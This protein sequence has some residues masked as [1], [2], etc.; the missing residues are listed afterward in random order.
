MKSIVC[1]LILFITT[2]ISY[3]QNIPCSGTSASGSIQILGDDIN[4]CNDGVHLY[5]DVIGGGNAGYPKT[6][7]YSVV[8]NAVFNPV[9]WVLANTPVNVNGFALKSVDDHW[10]TAIS[11]PFNF[12]FFGQQYSSLIIGNNGQVCFDLSQIGSTNIWFITGNPPM[13]LFHNSLNNCIVSPFFDIYAPAFSGSD[14]TYEILGTAPCRK[15]AVSWNACPAFA[16]TGLQS[17]HQIILYEG[18][19]E[20]EIN[21]LNKPNCSSYGYWEGIQNA[22]GTEAYN[23]PG[24]NGSQWTANN[25]S[26]A[27]VPAGEPDTNNTIYWMDSA[28]NICIGTGDT[29]HYW[30]LQEMAVYVIIGD[31]AA[32]Q[33]CGNIQSPYKHLYVQNAIVDWTSTEISTCNGGT[34]TFNITN[35]NATSFLW[36]FGDG[37]TL[38]SSSTSVAHTYI[39]L[40]PFTVTCSVAVGTCTDMETHP[41]IFTPPPMTADFTFSTISYCNGGIVTLNINNILNADSF[42]WNFG[43]GQFTTSSTNTSIIHT[44]S[45][46]GPFMAT[47]YYYSSTGNC[48]DS[49]TYPIILNPIPLIAS[50]NATPDSICIGGVITTTNTSNGGTGSLIFSWDWGNGSPLATGSNPTYTYPNAGTYTITLTATDAYGCTATSTNVVFVDSLPIVN[51]IASKTMSCVGEPVIFTNQVSAGI[52]NYLLDIGIVGATYSNKPEVNYSYITAGDYTVILRGQSRVCPEQTD[53]I[54]IHVDNYPIL[55]LGGPEKICAG[56][57]EITITDYLNTN[58]TYLWNTGATT[59]S[60]IANGPGLYTLTASINGCKTEATKLI[61]GDL[62]CIFIPNVFS[63]NNDGNNDYFN[64]ILP[65]LNYISHYNMQIYNRWGQQLYVNDNKYIKGWNGKYVAENCEPGTYFYVISIELADGS[66]K[67][68]SDDFLLIR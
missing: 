53:Q 61:V 32:G 60:I 43:D 49:V 3:A 4:L 28:T 1:T 41:V 39:G 54:Q 13:P 68:F 65:D 35:T 67:Q 5:V 22:T 33:G 11:L 6:D 7:T 55:D 24:R 15:F 31:T 19:N 63:P 48:L 20:I 34:A 38:I 50:F 8:Q 25:D 51:I 58:A 9:P 26:W 36:D 64:A 21:I 2:Y 16:C 30:P 10:S 18:T 27:F 44:Y 62:D 46:L 12:C 57:N 40:G 17:T 23:V 37:Q 56:K 59:N 47:L 45:G 66:K 42:Y 52:I 29:L 14:I